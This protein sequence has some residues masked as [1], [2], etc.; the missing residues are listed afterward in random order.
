[1]TYQPRPPRT[2]NVSG[3]DHEREILK[4]ARTYRRI[5]RGPSPTAWY[6]EIRLARAADAHLM[7]QAGRHWHLYCA[8][9][10]AESIANSHAR[11]RAR[12]WKRRNDATR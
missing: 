11:K 12:D 8:V 9:G 6:A 7:E 2:L 4:E 1:M 3:R 5:V 10:A